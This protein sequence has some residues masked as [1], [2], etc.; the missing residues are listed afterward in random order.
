[1][2]PVRKDPVHDVL[3]VGGAGVDT[4]V[5]VPS[6]PPPARDSVGVPPIHDYAGHTGTGVAL[7]CHALGL[8]TRFVDFIGDDP[9]GALVRSRLAEAGV[10]FTPVVTEAG[11]RRSVNL[12]DGTGVRT[13]LYDAR[14]PDTLRLP[15]DVHLPLL[16]RSRHVHLSIMDFARHLYDDIEASGRTVS[17]DLHDW[18]GEN[19]YHQDFAYRSDVVLL[20]AANLGGR[21]AEVM[22]SIVARGRASVVVATAGADGCHL[23]TR[24]ERTPRHFAAVRPDGPVLD[25]SGAGDAF[26]AAFLFGR[27]TGRPVEECVRYG[28]VAGAHACL[29]AG[30]HGSFLDAGELR[31]RVARAVPAG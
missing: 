2:P 11:T 5:R 1:M 24:G 25:A 10:E 4:V 29:S 18:D 26:A 13:S 28:L 27:L 16:R 20:S 19:P 23:L 12:V 8:A 6:L 21:L 7:G 31:R 30:T 3:V 14:H 22:A 9:Y 15:R 17:T